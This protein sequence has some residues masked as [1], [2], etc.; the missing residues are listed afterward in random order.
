[1]LRVAKV[2]KTVER[3]VRKCKALLFDAIHERIDDFVGQNGGHDL[4]GQN[5]R[6]VNSHRFKKKNC[7]RVSVN[8][9][10]ING[11]CVGVTPKY[12]YYLRLENIFDRHPD[13]KSVKSEYGVAHVRPYIG[14]PC[15]PRSKSLSL[16]IE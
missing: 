6:Q 14:N 10:R 5:G 9:D 3:V 1:M 7:V 8:D 4:V 15:S 16:N 2:S 11:Y 13:I 12:V